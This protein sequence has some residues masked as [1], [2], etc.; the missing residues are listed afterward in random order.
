MAEY[1]NCGRN[2]DTITNRFIDGLYPYGERI[3]VRV[4]GDHHPELT[5]VLELYNQLKKEGIDIE[6]AKQTVT[7]LEV[8]TTQFKVPEDA[9][10]TY[11]KTY[12][13]LQDISGVIHKM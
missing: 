6:E 12:E 2:C 9:C 7:E 13:L 10:P 1:C 3:V 5:T 11:A 4:H 8:V